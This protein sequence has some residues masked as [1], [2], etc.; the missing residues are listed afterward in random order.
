MIV[1]ANVPPTTIIIDG[2]SMYPITADAPP[3]ITILT[4]INPAPIIKPISAPG[5]IILKLLVK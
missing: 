4:M 5:S 3:L 2:I 1:D